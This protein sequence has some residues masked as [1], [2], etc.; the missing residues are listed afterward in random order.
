MRRPIHQFEVNFYNQWSREIPVVVSPNPSIPAHIKLLAA[1]T[2]SPD[3]EIVWLLSSPTHKCIR[4]IVLLILATLC[5]HRKVPLIY[6]VLHPR[7]PFP[8]MISIDARNVLRDTRGLEYPPEVLREIQRVASVLESSHL[9]LVECIVSTLQGN[10]PVKATPLPEGYWIVDPKEE[11]AWVELPD[12][13]PNRSDLSLYD[14]LEAFSRIISID[15]NQTPYLRHVDDDEIR[16]LILDAMINLYELYE[17]RATINL[18]QVSNMRWMARFQEGLAE[19]G[20]RWGKDDPDLIPYLASKWDLRM[21]YPEYPSVVRAARKLSKYSDSVLF[22]Y[23]SKEYLRKALLTG[24]IRVNPASFF[25]DPSLN[26]ARHDNE[27][28]VEIDLDVSRME[29]S[30]I[31]EKTGEERPIN[32][33]SAQQKFQVDRDYYVWCLSTRPSARLFFDFKADACLV[34]TDAEEFGRRINEA[35]FRNPN[36]VK[37]HSGPVIYYTRFGDRSI[38]PKPGTHKSISFE[39]QQEYRFLWLPETPT[40]QLE[41]IDITLGPLNDVAELV[42]V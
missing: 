42:L 22:K 20:H 26:I 36:V 21:N 4:D 13:E 30:I 38:Q 7:R 31:N 5:I 40:E 16:Q 35:M 39:Y 8:S 41:S 15:Y 18:F 19:A 3:G 14:N 29:F 10:R 28:E 2:R 34:I 1:E 27:L 25:V 33:V 11:C 12:I 32:P 6:P 9:S 24:N 17:D 37:A 23:G